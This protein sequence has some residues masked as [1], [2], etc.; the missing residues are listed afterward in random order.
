MFTLMS[1]PRAI[2][3]HAKTAFL[4]TK[5]DIKTTV[6]PI[7]SNTFCAPIRLGVKLL[8]TLIECPRYC[9]EPEKGPRSHPSY[10]LL[11]LVPRPSI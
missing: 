2:L 10:S 3:Y 8:V 6:I 7:V 1:I 4:F 5:S 11:G 9:S